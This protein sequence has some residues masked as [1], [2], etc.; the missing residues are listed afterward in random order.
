LNCRCLPSLQ[1]NKDIIYS[2]F[3]IDLIDRINDFDYLSY[4]VE[5]Q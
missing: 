3:V 1:I 5:I 4:N 2:M